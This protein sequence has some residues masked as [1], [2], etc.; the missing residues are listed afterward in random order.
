M[1]TNLIKKIA[2]KDYLIFSQCFFDFISEGER[3]CKIRIVNYD[4]NGDVQKE[5]DMDKIV[6]DFYFLLY[7]NYMVVWLAQIFDDV[8]TR[9]DNIFLKK[10][11]SIFNILFDLNKKYNLSDVLSLSNLKWGLTPFFI[12]RKPF[13]YVGYRAFFSI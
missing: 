2:D 7:G 5:E 11:S 4:L 3:N 12:S 6:N 8:I 13:V 1:L 9:K 10:M